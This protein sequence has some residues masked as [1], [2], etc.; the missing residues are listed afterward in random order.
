MASKTR[1]IELVRG[2][3]YQEVE[4]ALEESPRLLDFRDARGHN[5]LHLCCS[6][7]PA[8]KGLPRRAGIRTAD[9]LLAAGLDKDQEAFREGTWKATPVWYAVARG[10]NLGLTEHL[11]ELGAD[12]NHS[13]WAAGFREDVRAIRLLADFGADLDPVTEDTTPFLG[14]IKTSHFRAARALLELGADVD[15]RDSKGR[16]ALH[17]MLRKNSDL[18][19]FRMLVKY[20]PRGD[21]PDRDG[22]L[23]VDVMRRKRTPGFRELAEKLAVA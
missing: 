22:V 11:L 7:D 2:H 1:M 13:L 6:V 10:H 8:A 5:W 17:F 15:F 12:P 18:K 16:T 14:A 21:L 4:E 19:H 20:G 9:L 3:R 23:A